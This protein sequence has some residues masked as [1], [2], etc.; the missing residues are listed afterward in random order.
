MVNRTI[1]GPVLAS[2]ASPSLLSTLALTQCT[3]LSAGGC[4]STVRRMRQQTLN[5]LMSQRKAGPPSGLK[6]SKKIGSLKVNINNN[7]F[8][9]LLLRQ[10]CAAHSPVQARFQACAVRQC[11]T[12]RVCLKWL[13]HSI[14]HRQA[15][16]EK[17][18]PSSGSRKSSR[19]LAQRAGKSNAIR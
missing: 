11:G 19:T 9:S 4:P 16:S 18:R 1:A 15:L 5:V 12:A 3:W 6:G 13:S 14:V 10:H 8:V 2:V 17:L 7:I